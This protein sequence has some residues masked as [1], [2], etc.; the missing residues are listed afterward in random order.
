MMSQLSSW[1]GG[2]VTGSPD[3]ALA[4]PTAAP[5]ERLHGVSRCMRSETRHRCHSLHVPVQHRRKR[6]AGRVENRLG[7]PVE[8]V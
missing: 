4:S 3:V 2:T 1:L 7:M 5:P 6:M 8:R